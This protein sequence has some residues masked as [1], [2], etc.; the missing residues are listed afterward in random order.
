MAPRLN[1]FTQIT[2]LVIG[3]ILEPRSLSVQLMSA[4]D[5]GNVIMSERSMLLELL[6]SERGEMLLPWPAVG[7]LHMLIPLS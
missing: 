1:I 7:P 6:N 5:P 4:R 3:F 2:Y